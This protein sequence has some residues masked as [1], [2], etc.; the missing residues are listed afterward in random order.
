MKK[1]LLLAVLLLPATMLSAQFGLGLKLGYNGSTLTASPDTVSVSFGSGFH[2]GA[3]ARIGKRFY[4]QPEACYVLQNSRMEGTET[5]WEQQVTIGSVDIPVLAGFNLLN[6][7]AVKLRIFA[8]PVVSFVVNRNVKELS[9]VAGPLTG[10]DIN[11]VN[12]GLQAGAGLDFLFLTFDI[13]Y[14][15]GLNNVITKVETVAM[16]SKNNAWIISLGFK[17]L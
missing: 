1:T 17:L 7:K 9:E 3:Y 8:G 16:D 12:W 5:A 13:R 10:A 15:A 11:N 4:L 14:Q 2:A 6:D